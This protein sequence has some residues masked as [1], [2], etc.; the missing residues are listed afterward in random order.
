MFLSLRLLVDDDFL[1]MILD[2][3]TIFLDKDKDFFYPIKDYCI[4][5]KL[6][7]EIDKICKTKKQKKYM[8]DFLDRL[9][10][11]EDLDGLF[12]FQGN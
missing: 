10:N 6:P 2:S 4:N 3:K 11:Y 1:Q 5:R 12:V 7:V 9:A 8:S